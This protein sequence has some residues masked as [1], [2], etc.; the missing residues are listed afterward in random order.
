[1]RH[2]LPAIALLFALS[3]SAAPPHVHGEARLEIA[4]EGETLLIHFDSPLDNLL[5]F[6]HRPRTAG[7]RQAVAALKA[8]LEAP[9]KLFDLPPE[10]RCQALPPEIASPLFAGRNEAAHLDLDAD[11]RWRCTRPDELR[12]VRTQLF[13]E[14]PRLKRI[15]LDFA[16]PRG[17]QSDML[18]PART[19]FRW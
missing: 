13:A 10:A 12:A 18:T 2:L 4:L 11:Y 16:G 14:F 5:G 8:Q 7:E 15:R 6:E 19:G 1:M 3:L 17:Q 9:G